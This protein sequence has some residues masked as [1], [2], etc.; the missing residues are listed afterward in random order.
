MAKLSPQS[1]QDRYEKIENAFETLAPAATFGAM[2]LAQ[3]QTAIQPSIASRTEIERIENE[4]KAAIVARDAADATTMNACDLIVKGV[5]GDPNYG[6]DSA[7]YEAMGYIR[8]SQRKSGLTR[9]KDAPAQ[10]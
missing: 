2:T 5:V 10:T 8:K 7:L 1:T 3:F 4:L 9:K 6:D